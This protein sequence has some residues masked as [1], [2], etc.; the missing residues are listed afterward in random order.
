MSIIGGVGS[1]LGQESANKAN[2]RE[3]KKNR[4]WQ[5]RMS[6]TAHQRE[7]KDLKL[8]GLNPILSAKL[9][10][11]STPGGAQAVMQNSAKAGIDS[12][13]QTKQVA[14]AVD[15]TKADT[16]LKQQQTQTQVETQ[17]QIKQNV[18]KTIQDTILSTNSARKID[19]ANSKTEILSNLIRSTDVAAYASSTGQSIK[20]AADYFF[21]V[22]KT[23]YNKSTG[24]PTINMTPKGQ[25]QWMEKAHD[26]KY[27]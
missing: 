6:N 12:Y 17:T 18:L 5:E 10:G 14:A 20:K 11:A 7:I 3:A 27:K 16:A 1:Y 24:Y 15:N 25:P 21:N 9:G 26:V 13:N 4:I 2:S 19:I 22:I 23:Q 8:A